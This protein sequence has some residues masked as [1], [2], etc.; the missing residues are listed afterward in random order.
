MSRCR[1]TLRLRCLCLALLLVFSILG[2]TPVA[3]TGVTQVIFGNALAKIGEEVIVPVSV[4]NNPGFATFRFRIVYN[5]SDLEF[6]SAEKGAA[7]S[8]GTMASATN[9]EERTMT[10]TWF[11]VVNNYGDGEIAKLKFKVKNATCGTYPLKVVYLPEDFLNEDSVRIP[12]SVTEGSILTGNMI[13]GSVKSYG[14]SSEPVSIVLLQ[15]GIEVDKTLSVDGS[16]RFT[17]VSQGKYTIE[18]SKTNHAT[19]DYEISMENTDIE[20]NLQIT[21]LGDVTGDGKIKIGDYAKILAHVRGTT[22]LTG[23]EFVCADVTGD[24]K[25]KIGDYAKVLAHVRGTS[26]LW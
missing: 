11:S 15:D 1:T 16:Y 10:F 25:V 24:G 23:Y 20:Q 2:V 19:R 8:S 4:E 12:Y 17:S 21:L 9:P 22:V 18:V 7:L 14:N 6:V 13:S 26:L 5:T 3:A